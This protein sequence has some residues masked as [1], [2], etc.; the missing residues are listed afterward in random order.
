MGLLLSLL[1]DC[2]GSIFGPAHH[3]GPEDPKPDGPIDPFKPNINKLEDLKKQN[4]ED[5]KKR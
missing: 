4:Y 2:F 1:R 3:D 5:I